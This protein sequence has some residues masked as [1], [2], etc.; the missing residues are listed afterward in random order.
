MHPHV[1]GQGIFVRQSLPTF[2][3]VLRQ[4]VLLAEIFRLLLFCVVPSFDLPA[5]FRLDANPATE[6]YPCYPQS[7]GNL[8]KIFLLSV[9]LKSS[10]I[11][12]EA[13]HFLATLASG[14]FRSRMVLLDMLSNFPRELSVVAA[15]FAGIPSHEVVV[16]HVKLI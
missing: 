9:I 8:C 10:W 1:I 11:F 6:P 15:D 2:G 13:D 3:T 14:A 4:A 5:P 12:P 7:T 16:L